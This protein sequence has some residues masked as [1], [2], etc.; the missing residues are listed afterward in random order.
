VLGLDRAEPFPRELGGES[1]EFLEMLSRKSLEPFSPFIG[2]MQSDDTVIC[3]IPQPLYQ[4]RLFCPIDQTDDAVM[5]KEEIIG[6]FADG[7]SPEVGVPA[8]S[9]EQLVLCRREPGC[10]SLLLAPPLKVAKSGPQGEQ[11]SVDGI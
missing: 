3:R 5:A 9:Q 4:P 6:Y 8:D 11:P 2:E 1:L 7:R 10:S